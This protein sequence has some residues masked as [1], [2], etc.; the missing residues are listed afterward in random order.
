MSSSYKHDAVVCPA[1]SSLT[2]VLTKV[3]QDL[4]Q[5]GLLSSLFLFAP[6]ICVTH[7]QLFHL[8]VI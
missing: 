2:S 5:V 6:D 1:L 3:R 4:R 7:G 8:L